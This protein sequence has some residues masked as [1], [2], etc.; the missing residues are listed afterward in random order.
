MVLIQRKQVAVVEQQPVHVDPVKGHLITA[1]ADLA[2][3][4]IIKVLAIVQMVHSIHKQVVG[5]QTIA[6]ELHQ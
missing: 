3:Q 6:Q 4:L 5:H 2:Q 1:F